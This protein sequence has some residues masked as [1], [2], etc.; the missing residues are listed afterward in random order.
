LEDK[1]VE[2]LVT[3]RLTLRP[4]IALDADDIAHCLSDWDV[5]KMLGRSPYP[6][7]LADAEKWLATRHDPEKRVFS[8]HRQSLIGMAGFVGTGDTRS[9]G[10]WLGKPWHRRGFM[11]EA[12]TCL[13]DVVFADPELLKIEAGVITDNPA[14]LKLQM[15]LGFEVT[16]EKEIDSVP[17]QS[18]V[19][20]ITTELTR[21]AWHSRSNAGFLAA[22]PS[23]QQQSSQFAA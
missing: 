18:R 13:L 5:A 14:S 2:I 1:I 4:P 3:P 6:Y 16:G 8:I 22:K 15:G 9:L 19:T 23:L 21:E 12:L 7:S 11:G 17:R 10:Y 20:V